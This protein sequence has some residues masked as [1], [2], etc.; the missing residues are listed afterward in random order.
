VCESDVL[1]YAALPSTQSSVLEKSTG[2]DVLVQV[3]REELLPEKYI[4]VKK[5]YSRRSY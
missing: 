5:N 1:Y 3:I 4:E 2:G